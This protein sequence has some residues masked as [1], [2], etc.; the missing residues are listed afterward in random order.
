MASPDATVE[1][2]LGPSVALIEEFVPR[3]NIEAAL[4]PGSRNVVEVS[5]ISGNGTEP[6]PGTI[7]IS[8][9]ADVSLEERVRLTSQAKAAV[10][11]FA[12][13]FGPVTRPLRF[14]VGDQC[15]A[16]R[17]GY[18][19]ELDVVRMPRQDVLENCG[20]ESADVIRHEI[21]HALIFQAYPE[22]CTEAHL[23][24]PNSVRLHE[25]LADFFAH[26]LEP[27]QHFGEKY[28]V[29]DPYIREYRTDLTVSLSAGS[30]AQGNAITSHLLA[31][32]VT[33]QDIKNFLSHGDF[34]L[35][36]LSQ[37]NQSLESSL[38][39]DASFSLDEKVEN[40]PASGLGRYRLRADVPLDLTFSPNIALRDAHPDLQI[41]WL[42]MKKMPSEKF[43]FEQPS[44]GHFRISRTPE[45]DTEK[46]LARF[47]EGDKVI[48]FRPFYFGTD[49]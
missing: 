24:D 3:Q 39:R 8:A 10:S 22:V 5:K 6:K 19:Y 43:V 38:A 17:T 16:L 34:T 30:H 42:N 21:F 41:D 1:D 33:N 12:E 11:Y 36:A 28:K 26:Q 48:G 29:S 20:L 35:E 23:D 2:S 14:E 15:L 31:S 4:R 27:D 49:G 46:I 9:G 45:A 7:E 13:N 47:S 18:N 37:T 44:P 25:A 40:Y 32:E